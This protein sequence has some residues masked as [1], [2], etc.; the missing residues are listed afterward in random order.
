MNDGRYAFFTTIVLGVAHMFMFVGYD[1]G[2]TI[3]ESVLLSVHDRRPDQ[4]NQDAGYYGQAIVNA[5]NMFGHIIAPAALCVMNAKWSMAFGSLFFTL[6]CASYILMNEYAIYMSSALLGVLFAVFNAGYSRY[7]T[8]ISTEATIEK[9]NGLEWSIANLSTIIGGC[10]YIVFG[11]MDPNYDDPSEYRQ[12]SDSEIRL[13]YGGFTVIAILANVI[14]CFLP[15]RE[16]AFSISSTANVVE[17]KGGRSLHIFHAIW[18]T[19]KSLFDPLVLQLTPH[20]IYVGWQN[21]VWLSI[22]PTTLQFTESLSDNLFV[23]A[24]YLMAFSVGSM[25]IGMLMDPLSRKI[26]RFGQMP[27][28]M[29]A[30]TLQLLCSS[31]ILLS[32]PNLAT[33]APTSEASLLIPPNVPLAVLMGFLFGLLDSLNN[34]NRT[35]MCASVLPDKRDQVFAIGRFYQALS[36][37]VLLFCSPLLTTYW[38][39]GVGAVLFIVGAAFYTRVVGTLNKS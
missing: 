39:L 24:Y 35:V 14:F 4:M 18:L 9:V 23:T 12:Y 8:Q 11:L 25:T 32:T 21:S 37:S 13:M 28:L 17:E 7:L 22:Y 36:G 19:L 10:L 1:T 31:L 30:A 20:F 29:I 16:V 27:C 33:I 3:V 2:S 5:F 6:S 34:T 26:A 15:N 38:M